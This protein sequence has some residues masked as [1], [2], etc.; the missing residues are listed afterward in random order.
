M[1]SE[2]FNQFLYRPLLNILVILCLFLPGKDF[3]LA[4]IVLT[5]FLK[6]LLLPLTTKTLKNQKNIKKIQPKLKKIQ[7]KYK[8]DEV[9]QVEELKKLY[10]KYEI[11]PFTSLT[12]LLVQFPILIALY[13][14]FLRDFNQENLYGFIPNIQEINYSFFGIN[15]TNSSLI[16][17]IVAIVIYFF[18]L[19]FSLKNNKKKSMGVPQQFMPYFFSLITFM[20]LTRIPAA[21]S[22]YLAT[23]SLFAI[24]QKNILQKNESK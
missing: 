13:Q 19:Q 1:I 12:P 3:G 15:L 16:L 11:N 9:K 22:L 8:D 4:I 18:Q 10:D 6:S 7:K 23:S 20:V 14:V 5:V 17:A 21:V 2:F 24:I